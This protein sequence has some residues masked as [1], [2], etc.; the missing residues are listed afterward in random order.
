MLT[1]YVCANPTQWDNGYFDLLFGYEWELV[2]TPAGAKVWHAVDVKDEDL[3]PDAEDAL[4]SFSDSSSARS[5]GTSS[6]Q[7]PTPKFTH[8]S[9]MAFI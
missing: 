2:D 3:A 9:V 1:R 4:D 7:S 5:E 8:K 6:I